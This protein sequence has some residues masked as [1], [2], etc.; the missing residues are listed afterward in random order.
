M[1]N[2]YKSNSNEQ[3]CAEK[4]IF[5][6]IEK[7]FNITLKQNPKIYLNENKKT[8]VQPDFYSEEDNIIGEIFS[9]IGK[10]KGSQPRKIAN[11][12]L[13]MVLLDKVK[14]K[15]HKKFFVVCGEDEKNVLEKSCSWLSESIRRFEIKVI[16]IDIP[17]D[18]KGHV[19]SAQ[20]RQRMINN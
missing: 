9:H 7:L 2:T 8:Y 14:N 11:D 3:Q 5:H 16:K 12:I 15:K 20:D 4:F 10:Y 18:L 6:E 13:K 1:E 17:D 19:L